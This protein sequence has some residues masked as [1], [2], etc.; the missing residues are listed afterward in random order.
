MKR[1]I[2]ITILLL[3][4][5][6]VSAQQWEYKTLMFPIKPGEY[7]YS[8]ENT[9]NQY[10]AEGWE[11]ISVFVINGYYNIVMKRPLS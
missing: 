7:L 6:S 3:I 11:I 9:M 5:F 4:A 8:F 1:V 10:G 2:A